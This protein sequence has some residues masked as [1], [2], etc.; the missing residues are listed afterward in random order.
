MK[1]LLALLL[2][3]S[4][5][6]G[7]AASAPP[8]QDDDG[9]Q[10]FGHALTLV[11]TLVGIAARSDDP[12]ANLKGIDDVL[13]GRNPEANTA[14]AGL[15]QDATAD[16]PPQ[17]RDKVASIGRDLTTLARRGIA[18]A[19]AQPPIGGADAA[20]QARKDLTA[21]GLS[22]HDPKQFL[23]AVKR[24]DALAAELFIQGRGVNLSARD[25]DGRS[26]LDIARA[27]GNTRLAQ[28]L[29]RSL[30]AAR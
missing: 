10:A 25:A 15:L 22:Y 3:L 30:P 20:L 29:A 8:Q 28:L 23:D 16:M 21:M 11:Q 1:T 4:S 14:I 13:A 26:A 27:N 19:A 18:D 17:Y 6:S 2:A 24:D 12:Q 7:C 5:L 9:W